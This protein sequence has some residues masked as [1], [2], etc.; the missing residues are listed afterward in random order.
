MNE[1][2]TLF[3][4]VDSFRMAEMAAGPTLVLVLERTMT[5]RIIEINMSH[6]AFMFEVMSSSF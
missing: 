5:L 3:G 2:E 4:G 6:V 1:E